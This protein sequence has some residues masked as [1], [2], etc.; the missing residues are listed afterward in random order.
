MPRDLPTVVPGPS[1]YEFVR[2]H[3]G[4][5]GRLV[6]AGRELPDEPQVSSGQLRW[7]PGAM[8][9]VWGHHTGTEQ[10]A[11]QVE[12]AA[13]LFANACRRPSARHLR[14]LHEA[15]SD[16]I[17]RMVD[18]LLEQLAGHGVDR[19]AAHRVGHWLA[20][21]GTRRGPVKIGIAVLGAS[22]V[23][24]D[25]EV[26]RTL[27]AHDEFTLFAAVALM[28]GVPEPEAELWAL[29]RTVDGWGR[30]QCVERLRGTT[31]PAIR[32]WM[33][34]EGYRNS[35]MYEYL[36]YIAATTGGLLDALHQEEV[37]RE[38]LTSAGEILEAL[39]AGGPAENLD[40]YEAGADAVEAYLGHMDTRAETL[41]DFQAIAAIRSYLTREDG[42]DARSQRGWTA[43]RRD[44]FE[45]R[46]DELLQ[47]DLWN[48]R[49]AAGLRSADELE[50]WRADQ[51]ARLRGADTFAVHLARIREDPLDGPWSAAWEQADRDRAEQLAAAAREL[52]R[53]ELIGTGPADELGTGPAFRPHRALDWT[54]QALGD[55][56]GVGADLLLVGLQSPVTRNRNLA[57]NA[58]RAWPSSAW[59]AGARE[60][61]ATLARSDPNA[62]TRELA[63]EAVAGDG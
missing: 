4:P 1:I 9:G 53:L 21:T 5:D 63:A 2:A 15:L 7:A 46:C 11:E 30:I 3:L 8:D 49:I 56:V 32:A 51:A 31:D 61:A 12:R 10:A 22:G 52:L 37:G 14:A 58:L 20:T 24:P 42:W 18:P 50:F 59:P 34:R 19:A 41:G 26:V 40:D 16:D 57:L 33:L 54:L 27:G 13:D 38:L 43:T 55:H 47:R 60:L 62:R 23:G 17:L 25:L 6:E 36:A 39:V 28:N 44:A 48:D 45:A 35:I 29:A